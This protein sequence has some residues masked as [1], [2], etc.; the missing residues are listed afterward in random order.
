MTI[1]NHDQAEHWNN[2][3]DVRHWITEQARYDGM[4][5]PFTGCGCGSTTLA[6]AR[7]TRQGSRS[8]RRSVGIDARTGPSRRPER[9]THQRE[10]RTADVQVQ[11][12]P[13]SNLEL[14]WSWPKPIQ[15]PR[16]PI[17]LGR[18]ACPDVFA[19]AAA[20]R[21]GWLPIEGLWHR[22]ASS[23]PAP[24]DVRERWSKPR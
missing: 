19:D 8:R 3:D 4:L 17:H 2:S 5:A 18:R 23:P 11:P 10:L 9:W 21:G 13:C 24:Q 12:G 16:P 6:A 22:A 15:Q 7:R 14:S 1:A 20:Y